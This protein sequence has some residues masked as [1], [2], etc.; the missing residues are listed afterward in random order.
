MALTF[1]ESLA[2][3][4]ALAAQAS[5]LA[6][7]FKTK[8]WHGLTV[9]I[10]E[11]FASPAW[12]TGDLPYRLY[13]AVLVDIGQ[14]LNLLM[15]AQFA[16]HASKFCPGGTDQSVEFLQA[17]VVKIEEMKQGRAALEPILFLRMHV[18]QIKVET[19]VTSG[20][21]ATLEGSALIQEA[22]LVVEKGK[23][24]LAKLS[25]VDPAVSATV[26]YVSSLYFRSITDFAGY[27]RS[28]LMYLSFVSSD[29]LP[30][31]FKRNMAIDVSLSALLGE[32]IYTFGQLLQ[33]PIASTLDGTPHEWLHKM[34]HV[35]NDGDLH[36]YDDICLQYSSQLN[37]Q[38]ELVKHE[39][40]LR[41]KITL[42]SLIEMVSSLPA[43][44]REG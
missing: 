44:G 26:H 16:V 21:T 15:L 33:H 13:L 10:D 3:Q 35:F 12:N 40:R 14:K 20:G 41:E 5:D 42:M 39:R 11:C 9:K 34:L 17:C 24:E 7:L 38:P 19:G 36:K 4:E 22:K 6:S 30:D 8:L 18:A 23:E 28:S 29:S 37:A 32:G 1:L 43:G 31:D 27:Y 25:D 2:S